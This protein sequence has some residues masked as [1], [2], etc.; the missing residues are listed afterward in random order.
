[1][2]FPAARADPH[3]ARAVN[4]NCSSFFVPTAPRAADGGFNPYSFIRTSALPANSS[5]LSPFGFNAT[6][7]VTG[8]PLPFGHTLTRS[9]AETQGSLQTIDA[10]SMV[11]SAFERS[12]AAASYWSLPWKRSNRKRCFLP[13]RSPVFATSRAKREFGEGGSRIPARRV[14]SQS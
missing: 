9:F 3:F 11:K 10:D 2:A 6:V 13:E 14:P 5:V 7:T 12:G 4:T 8:W 1:M